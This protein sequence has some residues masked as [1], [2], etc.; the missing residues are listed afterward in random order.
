MNLFVRLLK[1]FYYSK[2]FKKK[3][4][5]FTI[6]HSYDVEISKRKYNNKSKRSLERSF[7]EIVD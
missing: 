2:M 4:L 3:Y 5:K 7:K 6:F 1:D